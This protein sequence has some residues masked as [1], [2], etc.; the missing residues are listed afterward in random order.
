MGDFVNL[1]RNKLGLEPKRE[2]TETGKTPNEVKINRLQNEAVKPGLNP[3]VFAPGR[4]NPP[5][6]GHGEVVNRVIEEAK[7]HG[8]PH[9]IVLTRTHQPATERKNGADTPNP[10]HPDKKLHWART[11]FPHANITLAHPEKPNILH[12]VSDL[13]KQGHRH[14]IVVAGSDQVDNYRETLNKYNGKEGPHGFYNFDK[15]D[16]ISAGEKRD[17]D[18]KGVAGVSSSKIK[19]AVARG[20]LSR[21]V[22]PPHITDKE[23]K[24]YVG[25]VKEGITPK[26]KISEQ[27]GYPVPVIPTPGVVDPDAQYVGDDKNLETKDEKD[28]INL[29]RR[30]AQ[31]RVN[32]TTTYEQ[33]ADPMVDVGPSAPGSLPSVKPSAFVATTN[34]MITGGSVQPVNA[35]KK[36]MQELFGPTTPGEHGSPKYGDVMYEIPPPKKKKTF[37]EFF[38]HEDKKLVPM[39]SSMRRDFKAMRHVVNY[40]APFLNKEGLKKT[41]AAFKGTNIESRID[42]S[43]DGERHDSKKEGTHFLAKDH[44]EHKAGTRV[45]ITHVTHEDGTI[46]AHTKKHGKIPLHKIA[47]DPDISKGRK[48]PG[49]YGWKVEK[50]VATNLGS[51]A[52][53]SSRHGHDFSYDVDGDGIPDVK[54]K[55]KI[56][57]K[58]PVVRGES[59]LSKAKAGIATVLWT[60]EKGWHY[61]ESNQANKSMY[62]AFKKVRVKGEDG[63]HRSIIEHLNKHHPDGNSQSFSVEA[64][65]GTTRHYLGHSDV[66]TLHCHDKETGNS[67]TYTV[68]NELKGAIPKMEHLDNSDIDKLDGHIRAEP[69][70]R[71]VVRIAH[72]LKQS[73]M[74]DLSNRKSG[75]TLEDSEHAS[76]FL[77]H[78][79]K[80]KKTLKE[81]IDPDEDD[82]YQGIKRGTRVIVKKDGYNVKGNV[83]FYDPTTKRY[84]ISVDKFGSNLN[85]DADDVQPLKEFVEPDKVDDE[86]LERYHNYLASRP[87]PKTG[88]K[89][90]PEMIAARKR[91]LMHQYNKDTAT[92][93]AWQKEKEMKEEVSLVEHVK[94]IISEA[95]KYYT[96]PTDTPIIFGR[97]H[98]DPEAREHSK[99]W[100]EI[101][102]EMNR[103]AGMSNTQLKNNP[104]APYEYARLAAEADHHQKEFNKRMQELK[105]LSEAKGR[106]ADS[107][108][109]FR[110]T[111]QGA[112]L[113]RKGAKKFGVKTAV[114]T[115]PSKLDPKGKAAKRRKS[116]CARMSGM[117]GP[118]KDEKGRPTRKAMSLRRWNCEANEVLMALVEAK[119]MKGDPCWDNYEMVGTKQKNGRE[120]PNCVPKK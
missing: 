35:R 90:T 58:K 20:K 74:R 110:P 83:D 27:A 94:S 6:M 93:Q 104:N 37:K 111:E 42:D 62:E 73:E 77:K 80:H 15:I 107:K 119:K 115:P 3:V 86:A 24:Q 113:T 19:A 91:L 120:V 43:K 11:F 7:K 88:E 21:N 75:I 51:K 56:R 47:K 66:N 53:K 29:R 81:E 8:A 9:H 76:H 116:F 72:H 41:K 52:A 68:G 57:E 25:D 30:T 12:Q 2:K 78:V 48:A 105:G 96:V 100:H 13:H 61:N 92:I 82:A 102:R 4:W 65:K 84:I 44:A 109:Y 50:K 79:T 28:K 10:M 87:D 117:K 40:V 85:V 118:M 17:P 114:T 101:Q 46:Y 99:K 32:Y 26:G 64:P 18:S 67:R 23:F 60:K 106:G 71:G 16:V 98:P 38:L 63:K 34:P 49:E 59:K 39:A 14:L 55:I 22:V 95:K 33:M 1:I 69:Q 45:H 70:T 103:N 97:N 36:R 54:G 112:G 5:H 31:K 89:P 108:G